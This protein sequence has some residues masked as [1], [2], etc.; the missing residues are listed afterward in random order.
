MAESAPGS[1]NPKSAIRRHFERPLDAAEREQTAVSQLPRAESAP[2]PANPKSEI[3][4]P[5]S[6]LIVL[7]TSDLHGRVH[8]HDALADRDFGQG[9][10]RV[11]AAVRTI[12]AEGPVLLLDSGDTIEGSP[13]QSLVFL[14]AV[15]NGA[16]P[17]V[18]AMNL[19]GYDAMAVGNHEFD[20][21]L[22]R[23]ERS[24]RE[25]RF[26]WLSANIVRE[27]GRPLFVPYLIKEVGGARVGI[28][29][30]T[31]Q[32]VPVWEGPRVVG[33]R[34]LDTL[35][36]ARKYVPLL[37][38][39]ERCDVVIVLTHQGLGEERAG[40]EENQAGAIAAEVRGIDLVLTGHTHTVVEPRR[41]GTAWV[42][43]P[44]RFGEALTRFDLK[45][46]PQGGRRRV[47]AISG[48]NIPM[49]DRA[50]D[51]EIVKAVAP[52]HEET[53]TKLAERVAEVASPV[54]ARRART[55]D[56][57]LLDWLHTVQ[58]REGRADLSFASLLPGSLPDWLGP[59]TLRQIWA[60][61]PYENTLVTLRA[62]GRQVRE[63]LEIAARCVSGIASQDG[64][65]VWQRNPAVWGYNCDTLE[66]ADYALDPTRPEGERLLFLRRNGA[67]VRDEEL[68]TVALNSYRASGGGGFRVWRDCP[69]VA[70]SKATLRDLLVDDARRRG[71][72]TF[73]T[74]ENWYLVPTLPEGRFRASP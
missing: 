27:D 12:R 66:G 50:V 46:E 10:A 19:L 16:D 72:L 17:I 61:Y 15:G 35:E 38:S 7:H 40:T 9:L 26:P 52:E 3:R 53:M 73:E 29:G 56:T 54:S 42:S 63:A 4:N 65:P 24:R 18:R 8:P 28:L 5:R 6:S 49:K 45:L 47:V 51:P 22:A 60:F 36:T 43:Q 41:V 62:T 64:H 2:V 34:F 20:F 70:E 14:G 71:R 44:G 30:L 55:A 69:R 57:P 59:L 58:R 11:A 25:S 37:R 33:L 21:G 67:P 68:F 23:M 31:T 13:T 74:N 48:R 32:L 39:K 1:A